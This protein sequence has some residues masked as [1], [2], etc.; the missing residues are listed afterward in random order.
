VLVSRIKIF[1]LQQAFLLAVAVIVT[2]F[3]SS[4]VGTSATYAMT[5]EE[6]STLVMLMR[7][8]TSKIVYMFMLP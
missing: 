2:A 3:T 5:W 7:L 1:L 4:A 6:N 8:S